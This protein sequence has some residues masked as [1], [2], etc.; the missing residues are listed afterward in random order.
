[1][2]RTHATLYVVSY[3]TV[4]LA[5]AVAAV[6]LRRQLTIAQPSYWRWL[7]QPWKL[8][9][10]AMATSALFFAAPYMRDPDWDR[11]LVLMMSTL[12][13]TTAPWAVGTIFGHRRRPREVWLAAAAWLFSA[14]WSYD[15]YWFAR[16]GFYPDTWR[17]N[18][19]ASSV[20]YG[21]A[22]LLWSIDWIRARGY[23]FAFRDAA[24]PSQREPPVFA[25]LA[26]PVVLMMIVVGAVVFVPFLVL[27]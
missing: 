3:V 24:W 13:F 14:S 26:V 23:L 22:G 27:R 8:A 4:M 16:R 10:F 1:M 12:T 15:L 11:G 9:T 6:R 25:R 5:A 21:A 2:T 18:L 7:L 19:A 17:L 20:L